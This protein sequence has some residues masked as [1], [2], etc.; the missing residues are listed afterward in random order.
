MHFSKL[1][2]YKVVEFDHGLVIIDDG[3]DLK[4]PKAQP[5]MKGYAGTVITYLDRYFYE[6]EAGTD[7]RDA[8]ELAL[9]A[10]G[11]TAVT[12]TRKQN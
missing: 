12:P 9:N 6:R 3:D 7:K 8:H 4:D 10:A 2:M 11:L 1:K 5:L